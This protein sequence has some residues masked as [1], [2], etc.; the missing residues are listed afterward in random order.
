MQVNEAG[1]ICL[2]PR[3]QFAVVGGEALLNKRVREL[4]RDLCVDISSFDRPLL[5]G[6]IE[7]KKIII[8][9][10]NNKMSGRDINIFAPDLIEFIYN[11][12]RKNNEVYMLKPTRI[13]PSS[14]GIQYALATELDH[15]VRSKKEDAA[16]FPTEIDLEDLTRLEKEGQRAIVL[17]KPFPSQ[18]VYFF[19]PIEVSSL[20]TQTE[21]GLM[22]C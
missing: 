12:D 1:N 17:I 18:N 20:D 6:N 16:V 2:P 7:G 8:I 9:F 11:S 4:G 13:N 14:G 22:S 19:V 10:R 21:S 5:Q 15:G 3:R